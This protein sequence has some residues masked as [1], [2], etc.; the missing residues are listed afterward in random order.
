MKDHCR[1]LWEVR[2]G[3]V[4]E[5]MVT[6]GKYRFTVLDPCL[7][8]MEYAPDGVFEDRASQTVFFRDMPACAYSCAKENGMLLLETEALKLCYQEDQP[9]SADSLQ[10]QLKIAP[11][12]CWHYGEAFET[13][14]GTVK[15]LDTV[16]GDIPLGQGVVSRN[17]FAV[18]DDSSTLV[19]E[20]DGWIGLRQE[21]TVDCY[22]FGFGH[23]Y[24]KAVQALYALTGMPPMLPAYALGNWWSRYYAYTQQE[25]CDL[26]D[27]FRA[28][29]IPFSVG[30]VDMDWHVVKIPEDQKDADTTVNG[31][32]SFRD[33]WT[34]YSW[35]KDL[36]PDY[37][38]FLKFLKERNLHTALN[39]H[40]H[41]GVCRHEDMYPEMARACGVDPAS[42]KRIPF[43]VLSKEFMEKY[44]DILHHPYERD[45]VDFWWMDWQQGTDYW[46]IHAPNKPDQYADP[47][48]RMDP[49]WMLNHLHILDIGRTGKRP[50]FFSRYAGVG[51]H[52]YPVGFSGDTIATWR[53]LDFQ[54]CF[55]ATA[56]NIGYSWWSHDIGGHV[57]A[58]RDDELVTRW[59]QLGVFSPINRLHSSCGPF[60]SKEPWCYGY[61]EQ[62]V[63]KYWLRLRHK[64]F[65]Y[66]YTMN[67]RSHTQG[68]PLVLPM[69][70][71]HPRCN[72][73]YG[74][75]NQYWF[76]SELMV[77]PITQ[78]RDAGSR[79][80]Q[81]NAWLPKGDW[82]DFFT[83][84]H[85]HSSQGRKMALHRDLWTIP[86]L[87]K[88]G[89]IV[90]LARYAEKD[91]RLL[92]GENMEV[93]V[94]PGADGS[95]CLYEDGGDGY[96][97]RNGV[98][99][100]TQM[101]LDWEN[102][103][104]TISPAQGD[105]SLIPTV[106]NWRICLR[107][108]HKAV[109][110][111]IPGATVVRDAA[112][113]TTEICVTA[114]VNQQIRVTFSGEQLIHDNSDV[115]DRCRDI[116]LHSQIRFGDK[117]DIFGLIQ[118][119]KPLHNKLYFISAFRPAETIGVTDAVRELLTLTQGE[120]ES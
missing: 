26:M 39:L 19:L 113:N 48:E 81:V 5:N 76:G 102:G 1:F 12:S 75:P 32:W 108:F 63:M 115:L 77:A 98:C 35:N 73:A 79:M 88:A 29:D 14:G 101:V 22:F 25:Y 23:Q 56:S 67:Y 109:L 21:N 65:P 8:R 60:L 96:E 120:F 112:S 57:G 13:L 62:A 31:D 10:L 72:D 38:G 40:P 11:A 66:L 41:A 28:E 37:Q 27:R 94:F 59:M 20:K 117:E 33:G 119:E 84:L 43:D 71:S 36:F 95:F 74:V 9:F 106:R 51:S 64:L 52:R 110:V 114:A 107:G 54:P 85:Y 116:L 93:L 7:I 2:P 99:A 17:G 103:S 97:F 100:K 58:S 91:N 15:T 69:Y 30:V 90:P 89:A 3:A 82:F 16:D 87:A 68:I 61:E 111:D 92:N 50:M 83:G 104:F 78:K 34:G 86:V 45:G 42:G 80:G 53:S 118:S 4:P 18:L 105:T 47:R 49:L 46:W 24:L 6:G 44:F 70:Y 55:T